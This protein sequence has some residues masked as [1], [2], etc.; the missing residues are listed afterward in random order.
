MT[1][2]I[3][4]HQLLLFVH[5]IVFALAMS[6]VLHGD[7]CFLRSRTLDPEW[8]RQVSGRV[9]VLLGLLW[10]TGASLVGM[11]TEA[12]PD[13]FITNSK[14]AMKVLVVTVLTLNGLLLHSVA[15]PMMLRGA[16]I[17]AI[18]CLLGA[19][20]TG[21][22][23][24]AS[25]VGVSRII[26]PEMTLL[27]YVSLYGVVLFGA[28]GI[29]LVFV[30]PHLQQALRATAMNPGVVARPRVRPQQFASMCAEATSK[31]RLIQRP[32]SSIIALGIGA[33][34]LATLLSGIP[35]G[36]WRWAS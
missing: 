12:K 31:H 14:L 1:T 13:I 10:L 8:L 18:A 16:R 21:S 17:A 9:F 4:V 30:R 33:L 11:S 28:A 25:F 2:G 34:L 29:A 26:A 36:T 35:M 24:Y 19:I 15:F 23:L 7:L 20:S 3:L 22:W 6:E 5:M 27:T 32:I